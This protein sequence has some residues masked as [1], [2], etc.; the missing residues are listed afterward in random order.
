M[1][2]LE[3][4][5][6]QTPLRRASTRSYLMCPPTYFE[7]RYEINPWMDAAVPVDRDL[8]SAQWGQLVAAYRAAG[9]TVELLPV[10]PDLPD[11]V[12]AANGATMVDGRVLIAKFA[13][14]DRAAEA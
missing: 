8:A 4:T 12:F 3:A 11:Q 6:I 10:S 14:P 5:P 13:N 7:V 1:T 2:S 9:H